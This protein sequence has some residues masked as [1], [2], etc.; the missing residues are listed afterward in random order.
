MTTYKLHQVVIT[1][2]GK[3]KMG[4]DATR[5]ITINPTDSGYV[6]KRPGAKDKH[7]KG[8]LTAM[9]NAVVEEK[10]S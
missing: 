10:L 4:Y 9:R 2:H 5:V 7:C 3:T 8:L 1:T 6:V